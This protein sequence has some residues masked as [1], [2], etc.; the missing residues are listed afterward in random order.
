M[1]NAEAILVRGQRRKV[2]ESIGNVSLCRWKWTRDETGRSH[3][4]GRLGIRACCQESAVHTE[5]VTFNDI[6]GEG[7]GLGP[8]HPSFEEKRRLCS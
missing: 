3:S 2:Y 6:S 1:H 5:N 4:R 8:S 7:M